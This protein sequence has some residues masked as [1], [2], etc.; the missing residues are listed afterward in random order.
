MPADP[1][2]SADDLRNA[3]DAPE[4]LTLGPVAADLGCAAELA[5]VARLAARTGAARQREAAA[6]GG[7]R[8]VAAWLADVYEPEPEYAG[9]RAGTPVAR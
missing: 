2:P 5:A 9:G 6:H 7:P 1:T 4:P 3:F 8:A